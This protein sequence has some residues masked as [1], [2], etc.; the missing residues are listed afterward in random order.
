MAAVFLGFFVWL[1]ITVV[2][3]L[4]LCP[5]RGYLRKQKIA[6]FGGMRDGTYAE[7][8]QG[9]KLKKLLSRHLA[10]KW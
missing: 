2:Y 7:R 5:L 9:S 1:L 3:S 6:T 10:S 4:L 8:E